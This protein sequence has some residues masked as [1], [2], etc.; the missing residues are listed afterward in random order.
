MRTPVRLLAVALLIAFT[1]APA[2][3]GRLDTHLDRA[4]SEA[5]PGQLHK[6]NRTG[7]LAL[8]QKGGE[9]YAPVVMEAPPTA[10]RALQAMGVVVRTILPNGILTADVPVQQL[11]AVAALAEVGKV[12]ASGRVRMY[13]DLSNGLES[14]G[15]LTW[16]MHNVRTHT[17]AG[18][19]VGVID[20]GL[21]WTHEDFIYDDVRASRILYYW[22]QSDVD[23]DRVPAGFTY[24]HEYT[25]ADFDAAVQLWA[26]AWTDGWWDPVDDPT[27]PIKASAR[28][29]DGHGTHVTGTAAGDG[30]GSG[31]MGGAPEA[32]IIF[33]K[34]DFDGDR[35][36]D[37]AIIDGVN[38]I[39]QKAQ[40]LGRPAVINM[41]LGSDFGPH[42]GTTLEE[43]GIDAL[44]GP[45]KVV[46]VAA[47][48]PG[49]NNW[50]SY[51]GWGFAMHGAGQMA[52]D[53]IT[54]RFPS[55]DT[56]K[57]TYVFF[58][59]WYE[60]TD[61][62]RIRV[63][64]PSGRVYPPS[65]TGQYKN[66]WTTGSRM[67]AFNTSEGAI[68]VGNGG[69]QFG[70]STTNGDQEVYIEISDYYGVKP[71]V[72]TWTIELV[73]T[74]TTPTTGGYHAWYG[75]SSNLVLGW[76][77]EPEPR[78]ATPRFGGR[79]SDNA[80][81]IGNPASADRVIAVA[82]YQTRNEWPYVYGT[83][84]ST[85]PLIQ[86]YDQAPIGYYDP[87][88]LGHLAYFSG[89]GPRRDGVLK[90]E[91][92]APGVGIVSSLSHFVTDV[93][94]PNKC[95]SYRSG[96]PYH[97]G[98]NRVLPNLEAT[99]IQGTSMACPNATGAIA[100]LLQA[101]PTLDD[102]ALR[103][104]FAAT[105]RHD[106]ATDVFAAIPYTAHTDTDPGAGPGLPNND[107]GFGKLDLVASLAALSC[108]T[109]AD[110]DDADDCTI[111]ACVA[112]D[113][114]N[115][116]AADG[117]ACATGLCCGGACETPV[118]TTGMDCGDGQSCTADECLFGGTC[119]ATCTNTW[120]ACGPADGCC[121]AGCTAATDPDCVQSC[122]PKGATCLAN[123]DCCSLSCVGK[124]GK[125]TCK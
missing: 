87:F 102:V 103:D 100:L 3:A 28:D 59:G 65:L 116:A 88:A 71:A 106:A 107:W 39:F 37:A 20:S 86:A 35:N 109:A 11:R 85:T 114:V 120:A 63:T 40:A 110:C 9:V 76:R 15:A 54:F 21:D 99:V 67:T 125:K 29:Y 84:C 64:T 96:G 33:V 30:S 97:F 74:K 68:V 42:D 56:S 60:G 118:C 16:G 12:E 43:R 25:S 44:T 66:M 26:S 19:I 80:V 69:D 79:E 17:G 31:F 50:S 121:A 105:A 72:G 18:V 10:L 4:A 62:C 38:Y 82:A 89:R 34:F 92:A 22:D 81:T 78:S 1:S 91:I 45:G 41:S 46:V 6:L 94:W 23:D 123:A 83:T 124:P 101:D 95:V 24:G 13:N 49:S 32:D 73:P 47:G 52:S 2:L 5:A 70:W 48:N 108:A 14:A 113:C 7:F 75:V 36:S 111:D 51:L 61:T 77:A 90:P 57:E 55:F 117:T 122:L 53:P 27:Y 58:D 119:A 93:E 115:T 104:L 8:F 98:M 112:G